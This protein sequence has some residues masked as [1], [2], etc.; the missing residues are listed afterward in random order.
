MEAQHGGRQRRADVLHAAEVFDLTRCVCKCNLRHSLISFTPK[1]L[2]FGLKMFSQNPADT[3]GETGLRIC[4]RS[5]NT[6]CSRGMNPT[7]EQMVVK[8]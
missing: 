6:E 2:F 7:A 8:G 4:W 5:M 1:K 3:G